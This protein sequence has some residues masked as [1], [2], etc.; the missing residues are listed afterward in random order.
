M[1]LKQ[2]QFKMLGLIFAIDLLHKIQTKIK[3]DFKNFEAK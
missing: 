3:I 2:D 1:F